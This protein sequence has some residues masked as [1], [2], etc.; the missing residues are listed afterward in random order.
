[1]GISAGLGTAGLQPAVCTST[2]RPAAPYEG[3]LIY[4]TDTD[5][6][7]IYNGSAWAEV[8]SVTVKGDIQTFSTVPT[9]LGVGTNNYVL[10]ADSSASTGLK[11]STNPVVCTSSTRPSSPYNGMF[12]YETDTGMTLQYR[13]SSW[14]LPWEQRFARTTLANSTTTQME[15][16]SIPQYG[17]TLHFRGQMRSQRAG[18]A[19]A[20]CRFRLNGVAGGTDYYLNVGGKYQQSFGYLG[21]VAA[22]GAIAGEFGTY[23][24]YIPDYATNT[25]SGGRKFVTGYGASYETGGVVVPNL[26][27]VSTGIGTVTSIQIMDDVIGYMTVGSYLEVWIGP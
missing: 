3:Q 21:N 10:M 12:I 1:M 22:S 27:G 16:A 2:T 23:E 18:I 15:I 13:T 17:N 11:W 8:S 4:E 6:V 24:A 14:V 20:G 19:S 25:N 9:K 7:S 5:K 26:C